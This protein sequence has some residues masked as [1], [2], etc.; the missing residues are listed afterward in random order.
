MYSYLLAIHVF[1]LWSMILIVY[2]F[3][4]F[5]FKSK[6][7]FIEQKCI[8]NIFETSKLLYMN[9]WRFKSK[10]FAACINTLFC[11][12]FSIILKLFQTFI[13]LNI[14]LLGVQYSN[15]I[16]KRFFYHEAKLRFFV[17]CDLFDLIQIIL[18]NLIFISICPWG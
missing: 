12:S 14:W 4:V 17:L 2:N 6:I 10:I 16:Y 18:R 9:T 8:F 13:P 5:S 7:F 11:R 3:F 15:I 1:K